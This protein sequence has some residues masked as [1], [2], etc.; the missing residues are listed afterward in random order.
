[1][2]ALSGCGDFGNFAGA[3]VSE[4]HGKGVDLGHACQEL[5]VAFRKSFG[6]RCIGVREVGHGLSICG[7]GSRKVG[8]SVDGAF[9]WVGMILSMETGS[10]GGDLKRLVVFFLGNT[11]ISFTRSRLSFPN[12]AVVGKHTGA[13]NAL[14]SNAEHLGWGVRSLPGIGK[15]HGIFDLF[16]ENLDWLVD[17]TWLLHG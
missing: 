14:V 7:C 15:L 8:N 4:L 12:L 17:V 3:K 16:V 1:M 5:L 9:L 6:D 13:E 2:L 10:S 11:K